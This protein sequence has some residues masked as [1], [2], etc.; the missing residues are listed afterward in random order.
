MDH[1]QRLLDARKLESSLRWG[2][3][4]EGNAFAINGDE[5]F[6]PKGFS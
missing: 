6:E 4:A 5:S 1:I 2:A 3:S